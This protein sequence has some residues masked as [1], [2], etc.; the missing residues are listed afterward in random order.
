LGYEAIQRL[1]SCRKLVARGSAVLGLMEDSSDAPESQRAV[2]PVEQGEDRVVRVC[3]SITH[4]FVPT[5]GITA[6]LPT[7]T[8]H[9]REAEMRFVR[10]TVNRAAYTLMAMGD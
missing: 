3:L 9:A 2:V 8:L 4:W 5:S 1:A 7:V 6:A 10:R